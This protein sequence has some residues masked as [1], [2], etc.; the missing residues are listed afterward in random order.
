MDTKGEEATGG[1]WKWLSYPS[2]A[3]LLAGRE[4]AVIHCPDAPMSV[5]EA[6]Q[7]LIAAAPD[8]RLELDQIAQ[9]LARDM[10]NATPGPLP[11]PNQPL[12]PVAL[13]VYGMVQELRERRTP[14]D[15]LAAL[16]VA[17]PPPLPDYRAALKVAHELIQD[18]HAITD[19]EQQP[20]LCERATA[21]LRP[22]DEADECPAVVPV[23][24][25]VV[26]RAQLQSIEWAAEAWN[27]AWCC[28]SRSRDVARRLKIRETEIFLAIRGGC[29]A[30]TR[31]GSENRRLRASREAV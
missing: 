18:F 10:V 26:T 16:P 25:P 4:R 19:P 15:A 30:W 27:G 3:K 12:G 23:P 8:M 31:C 17:D 13:C 14:T 7:A 21:I 2:G 22:C 1:P 28:P 11:E 24:P 6:D 9:I 20:E 5:N 29:R